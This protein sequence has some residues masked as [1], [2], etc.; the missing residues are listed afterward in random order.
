VF[1]ETDTRDEDIERSRY[2]LGTE[3]QRRPDNGNEL[4]V[5]IAFS[6]VEV[7]EFELNEV[8]DASGNFDERE[9]EP[10]TIEKTR[11][12]ALSITDFN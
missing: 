2:R 10:A 3:W 4:D 11:F 6:K 1:T 5:S 8:F 12:E 7:D 9:D